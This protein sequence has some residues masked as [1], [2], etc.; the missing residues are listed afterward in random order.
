MP[1]LVTSAASTNGDG[2]GTLL[3]FD[4]DGKLLGRFSE[5]NRIFDPR[6]LGFDQDEGL[7]GRAPA[8]PRQ[9]PNISV[10]AAARDGLEYSA[11]NCPQMGFPV[12][13]SSKLT[14]TAAFADSRTFCPSTEATRPK[15]MKW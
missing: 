1:L 7:L 6:C 12:C 14:A 11:D 10:W 9:S 15:P 3:G 8:G 2:Y 13:S 5:D 4:A